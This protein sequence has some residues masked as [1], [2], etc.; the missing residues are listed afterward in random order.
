MTT[1][2]ATITGSDAV[3]TAVR[4]V[5]HQIY[6][7]PDGDDVEPVVSRTTTWRHLRSLDLRANQRVLQI[8]TGSGYSAALMGHIVRPGGH[9]LTLDTDPALTARAADLFAAHG[10]RVVAATGHGLAGHPDLAPYDRIFAPATPAAI[11]RTWIDQLAPG[12]LLVTG[13]AVSD[14]PGAD[15]SAH[16]TK[17]LTGDLHVTV[18][19]TRYPLMGPRL[20]PAH[21]TAV[22]APDYPGYYLAS[23]SDDSTTA[24]EILRLLRTGAA[25]GW[26][27][28]PGEFL[29][30]KHWLLAYRP[31][32]LF[33]AVTQF[34]E[35]IGIGGKTPTEYGLAPLPGGRVEAAMITPAHF[36]ARPATSPTQARLV[37]LLNQW[38]AEGHRTT[39]ELD[40]VLLR[41]HPD[42]YQVRLDE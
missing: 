20:L 17:T 38:R 22:R 2:R 36:I 32:G 6:L 25:S 33:T 3:A 39:H 24:T 15:A 30:L 26:P 21:V 35:G 42:A 13:C 7:G 1:M 9:V 10:H 19:A 34:G 23:T 28:T 5:P 8:G 12:G 37:G 14:L 40:A 16:I 4:A 11:P 31:A 41:P 27:G 18:H 29:E